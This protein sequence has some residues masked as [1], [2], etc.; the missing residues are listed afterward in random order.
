M[1][2]P[3]GVFPPRRRWR[4]AAPRLVAAA[5]VVYLGLLLLV[6]HLAQQRLRES[7]AAQQ[8][9][10]LQ[11]R[12]AA[13]SYFYAE[14]RSDLANLV[15]SQPVG[16]FF[17][18]RDLGMSMEYGLRAS[19]VAVRTAASRL[20]AEARVGGAPVYRRI[21]LFDVDGTPLMD[22]QD[23]PPTLPRWQAPEEEREAT[24]AIAVVPTD[25]GSVRLN[26]WVR[27][28][29]RIQGSMVSWVDQRGALAALVGPDAGDAGSIY[30]VLSRHDPLPAGTRPEDLAAVEGTDLR[31]LVRRDPA[32]Q[33]SALASPWFLAAL[34]L[35]AVGLIAIGRSLLNAQQRNLALR[36]RMEAARQQ[37]REL[38]EHNE[39]LLQ[40]I[41]KREE[42]ERRLVYQV[43]YDSLTGLPNRAL[44]LDRLEQHLAVALRESRAVLLLYIDIDRFKRV[45]DSLGHAAG[46]EV[47]VQTSMRLSRLIGLGDTL[48]RIAADEFVLLYPDR[49]LGERGEAEAQHALERFGAP[50]V[51]SG[52]ELYLGA[53]IGIARYPHHGTEAEQLLKHADLAMKLAKD[54]GG[55]RYCAFDPGLDRQISEDMTIANLLRRAVGRGELLLA[56]QPQVEIASGRTVGVEAL[57]RWRSAELGPVSPGRFI[58]IAEDAGL[59]QELGAWVLKRACL[60]AAG[61]Q[62]GGPCRIAVNVSALQ[63]AHPQ[64]FR[65]AVG[66]ALERSGL[67]PGLLEL[68]I[69]ERV[70]LRDQPAIASLLAE[71]DRE[72]VR[73]AIDDFGT[74][75]SSLS[76]L[77]RFPFHLL[78]ID[79]AFIQGVPDNAGDTE[80]TR[81][82]VAMAQALGLSV[83]AE[84]VEQAEQLRFLADLRC[85]LAQG[86]LFSHA[87]P[88]EEIAGYV[89]DRQARPHLQA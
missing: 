2:L 80:L 71:L 41:A 43:N 42:F 84:G 39:R 7:T 59:I 25:A 87:I 24:A 12:A 55:G 66:D 82:I 69:T 4:R 35:L 83:L 75:Y 26:A 31:L 50:F 33:R 1:E 61:W 20:V 53:S 64:E 49:P 8:A 70:L 15:R 63:L 52:K 86:F 13:L 11:M 62:A 58:P 22:T 68:E 79:R 19:L 36:V 32:A 21:A 45:N 72:G 10:E 29:G 17:A 54:Q 89:G 56:Y 57:L 6:T 47:L 60:E 37:R 81:A 16:A 3:V 44:V 34:V 76:Y 78:K 77:R 9:L 14:R 51:V 27:H 67:A 18:N 38:A 28:R 46:D 30:R 65:R 48:A 73:L 40:E 88:P 23:D 85:D 5:L 74:G